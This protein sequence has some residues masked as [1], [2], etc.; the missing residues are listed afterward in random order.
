MDGPKKVTQNVKHNTKNAFVFLNFYE[1]Y[2]TQN[3]NIVEF[4]RVSINAKLVYCWIIVWTSFTYRKEF[5]LKQNLCI[6]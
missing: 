2:L 1:F 3:H 6:I 5:Q 4:E